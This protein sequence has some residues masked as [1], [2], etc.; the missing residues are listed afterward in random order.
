MMCK[1]K[2]R[3]LPFRRS[4]AIFYRF[5]YR[6]SKNGSFSLFAFT[7]FLVDHFLNCLEGPILD[8]VAVNEDSGSAGNT[9]FYAFHEVLLDFLV[10]GGILDAFKETRH[11]EAQLRRY[12]TQLIIVEFFLGRRS[13]I[14]E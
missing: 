10:N 13:Y 7:N 2:G 9:S 8:P 14:G 1:K 3:A 6:G 4:P 11:V 5:N 12:L